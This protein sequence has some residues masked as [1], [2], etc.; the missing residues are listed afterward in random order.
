MTT[1]WRVIEDRAAW[2]GLVS[3]CPGFTTYSSFEWGDFKRRSWRVVRLAFLKQDRPLGG[4]QLLLKSFLGVTVGW[5]P[6]GIVLQHSDDFD[7][8]A[9]CIDQYLGSRPFVLRIN[10]FD[11][12]S[13]DRESGLRRV[14]RLTKA[15]HLTRSGLTVEILLDR[16]GDILESMS[17]NHRR[18]YRRALRHQ[19]TFGESDVRVEEFTRISREMSEA[20][21]IPSIAIT[22]DSV[23]AVS[24]SF[25]DR[26]R[27][28][29]V[30]HDGET[31]AGCLVMRFGDYAYH[32]LAA[33]TARG[34]NLQASY[35]LTKM[36]LDKLQSD[37]VKRFDFG[38]ISREVQSVKGVSYFKL[39][40]SGRAV[41]ALGEYDL[42][43]NRLLCFFFNA[44]VG[45]KFRW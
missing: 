30:A 16:C 18:N 17:N 3:S 13:S 35:Y 5:C 28:Y 27:M 32:Y 19:L 26:M 25:G 15:R 40:F 33:T 21:R 42:S 23:D 10:C 2:N 7:E 38:G 9:G 44:F 11:E 29:S 43:N 6:G 34:R 45:R 4:T 22:F 24:K 1:E 14:R 8:V 31:V 39:G 41:Q 36:L 12:A 37:G 20:K